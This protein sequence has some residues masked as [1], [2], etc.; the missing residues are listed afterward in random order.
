[1]GLIA[2]NINKFPSHFFVNISHQVWHFIFHIFIFSK[3]L[4]R[5]S[6]E[7]IHSRNIQENY[8]S[9]TIIHDHHNCLKMPFYPILGLLNLVIFFLLTLRDS[10]VH[11]TFSWYC[12]I[13][14]K[15]LL[16]WKTPMYNH[17]SLLL[18]DSPFRRNCM[19]QLF[20]YVYAGTEL[21][22]RHGQ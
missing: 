8:A 18:G 20:I 22:Y 17:R 9:S 16:H 4:M 12:E 13:F 10:N 7:R 1:M 2:W 15:G 6:L 19:V 11:W 5:P 14:S 3:R 21:R